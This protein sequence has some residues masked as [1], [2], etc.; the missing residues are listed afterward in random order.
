MSAT[1]FCRAGVLLLVMLLLPSYVDEGMQAQTKSGYLT[2]NHSVRDVVNNP[3]FKGFG[4]LM[5]PWQDNTKYFDTQL[6]QVGSLMPY[7]SHVNA[8][9][10][11]GTLNHLIDEVGSGKI[12][13]YDF[14]TDRQK[15]EGLTKKYTGL[16]SAWDSPEHH[17]QSLIREEAFRMSVRSRKDFR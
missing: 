7:H 12:I 6:D 8:D 11:V 10:V 5:L 9:A 13:F 17:S 14:Y 1:E 16:F 4:D 15:Q 3:A 2:T